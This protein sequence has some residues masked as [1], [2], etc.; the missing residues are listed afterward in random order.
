MRPAKSTAKNASPWSRFNKRIARAQ[1]H[2]FLC[3]F[4]SSILIYGRTL[5]P[6]VLTADGRCLPLLR[7]T[8]RPFRQRHNYK[9]PQSGGKMHRR[10]YSHAPNKP[11]FKGGRYEKGRDILT[12]LGHFYT[13]TPCTRYPIGLPTIRDCLLETGGKGAS[14]GGYALWERAILSI[15]WRRSSSLA[16][17]KTIL[18]RDMNSTSL[19]ISLFMRST[20]SGG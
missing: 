1:L 14:F 13:D 18:D 6:P 5:L 4:A 15:A 7:V 11:P 9:R 17:R 2:L 10:L 19:V 16:S 20:S 12:C 3:F 8:R